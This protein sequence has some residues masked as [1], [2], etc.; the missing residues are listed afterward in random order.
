MDDRVIALV[1]RRP[2]ITEVTLTLLSVLS[3][4]SSDVDL[5]L[6]KASKR[7]AFRGLVSSLK[8][9]LRPLHELY[10]SRSRSKR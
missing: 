7:W 5:G 1:D 10:E 6:L 9:A 4:I 3:V 8:V 2:A